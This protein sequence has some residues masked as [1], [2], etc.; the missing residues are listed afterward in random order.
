MGTYKLT[1]HSF[2][3]IRLFIGLIVFTPGTQLNVYVL[4]IPVILEH[5]TDSSTAGWLQQ[6]ILGM[7]SQL[8]WFTGR[9][10]WVVHYIEGCVVLMIAPLSRHYNYNSGMSAVQLNMKINFYH[11]YVPCII[12]M[13]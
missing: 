13:F 8:L 3:A 10:L 7:G 9:G 2:V 4:L 1:V 5:W 11:R 12:S 6:L